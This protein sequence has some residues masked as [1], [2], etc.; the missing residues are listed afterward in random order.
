MP[1]L[2]CHMHDVSMS[3]FIDWQGVLQYLTKE[4]EYERNEKLERVKI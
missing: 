3:P 2:A 1:S 4:D